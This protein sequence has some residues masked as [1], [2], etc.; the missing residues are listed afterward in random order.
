MTDEVANRVA[1]SR[2]VGAPAEEVFAVLADPSRHAGIDGSGMLRFAVGAVPV[3]QVGDRFVVRM[4]N[5]EMGEYEM[6][7]HVIEF[8]PNRRI[9]REPV[10]SAASRPEDQ[11]AI[12][13][14]G[15]QVWGFEVEPDG[16]GG[17]LVTEFYDCARSPEW[18]QRAVKHGQRWLPDM[19][20]TLEFLDQ[21]CSAHLMRARPGRES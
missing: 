9:A 6:T 7:N 4:H 21:Q 14:P 15:R 5:D 16:P 8:E 13:D 10:M 2:R 19:K 20:A 3:T 18:L 17:T 11:D 12:D 1:V